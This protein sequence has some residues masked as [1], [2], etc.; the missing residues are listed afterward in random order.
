MCRGP[1]TIVSLNGLRSR[2]S[3]EVFS[4]TRVAESLMTIKHMSSQ[5]GPMYNAR[6]F[7]TLARMSLIALF[8]LPPR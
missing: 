2:A 6:T 3:L 8:F 5:K 1:A 7:Q 4:I